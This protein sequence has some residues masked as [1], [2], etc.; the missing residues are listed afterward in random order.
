VKDFRTICTAV[1]VLVLTG[2][3]LHAADYRSGEL[4]VKFKT[5]GI[6]SSSALSVP[7][8]RPMVIAVDDAAAAMRDLE[9]SGEVEYAE[10]NYI[11]EA[12]NVPDDW[13]YEGQWGQLGL[14]DAWSLL[15]QRDFGVEVLIAV[16]DSGVDLSHPELQ[17]I[18]VP[19]YDFP[20]NDA[21]PE[22]NSGHGTKVCGILGAAGDNGSGIAGVA[23]D[24]DITIMPVKFMDKG[25]DGKTTGTLSDAIAA[26][27]FAV[28]HGARIIKAS[29][30]FYE[31]S[32]ALQDALAYAQ[33]KGVLVVASAGNKGQ[34]NDVKEHYPSNYPLDNIT[35]VA[36]MGEDGALA[37]FSNYGTTTVDVAAPGV[38]I[39]T[40][41]VNGGYVAWASGTSFATPFVTGIAAMV[42][43]QFPD[44]DCS[45]L[46]DILVLSASQAPSAG[47]SAV[48]SGG[49]VNAYQ[50]LVAGEG[51]DPTTKDSQ[52]TDTPA[53]DTTAAAS[54][55]SGG[56]GCL[57]QTA[58]APAPTLPAV[59]F[60]LSIVLFRV[61]RRKDLE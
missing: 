49:C 57:I 59:L 41:T 31:Y 56:G 1:L 36:A 54:G 46:R 4:I 34:N 25:A 45:S 52:E 11:I 23:W 51:Y 3:T 10:P 20:G 53:Q 33:A 24:V 12:E 58:Q 35:A 16:V 47:S 44:L 21:S 5:K 38:G 8:E 48:A 39:T 22:D 55:G 30:G 7:E 32:R 28:D 27:Y 18:I 26:I 9:A 17:G 43:S 13:P 19:G 15:A 6:Q 50:A 60:I 37:S 2:L 61:H 14:E 29:G 40:T 42:L